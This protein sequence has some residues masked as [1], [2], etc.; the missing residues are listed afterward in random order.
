MVGGTTELAELLGKGWQE[1]D[2]QRLHQDARQEEEVQCQIPTGKSLQSPPL[3]FLQE[4]F[5]FAPNPMSCPPSLVILKQLPLKPVVLPQARIKKI[6]QSDEEV[7]KVAAPVPVIISRALEMFAETL[8][9]SAKQV[10]AQRGART[11]TPSHLKF[12]IQSETRFDFLRD[13]VSSVPDLQGD[14]DAIEASPAP[15]PAFGA[16]VDPGQAIRGRGGPGRGSVLGVRGGGTGRRRGRPPKVHDSSII[17]GAKPKKTVAERLY[18]DDEYDCEELEGEEEEEEKEEEDRMAP[19][20]NGW[21]SRLTSGQAMSPGASSAGMPTHP[22][23]RSLSLPQQASSGLPPAHNHHHHHHSFS[24]PFDIQRSVSISNQDYYLHYGAYRGGHL[25]RPPYGRPILPRPP[26]LA[27]ATPPSQAPVPGLTA[28][29]KEREE[30]AEDRSSHPSATN[31]SFRIG[32]VAGEEEVQGEAAPKRVE[33]SSAA[34][35]LT[36]ILSRVQGQPAGGGHATVDEDY[37]C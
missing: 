8:L 2:Q 11:L 9:G 23:A 36:K 34:P 10:T 5:L 7:G 14:V 3:A 18:I 35:E 21:P 12:C 37:D 17:P 28:F 24:S 30:D 4:L 25:P 20:S 19:P 16:P 29:Y 33:M 15:V 1:G 27:P 32:P 26:P 13:L 31:G 22:Y 6:M